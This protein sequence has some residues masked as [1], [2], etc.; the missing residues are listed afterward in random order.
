MV[1]PSVNAMASSLLDPHLAA[2]AVV[3]LLASVLLSRKQCHTP[4]GP[5][6]MSVLWNLFEIK[7][8]WKASLNWAKQHGM[9][10]EK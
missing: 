10:S 2:I 9:Y 1:L 7:G 5:Q 6:G 4:P 8:S 3:I